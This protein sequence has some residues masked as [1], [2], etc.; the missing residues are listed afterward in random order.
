MKT[1]INVYEKLCSKI[2]AKENESLKRKSEITI[3][4][5]DLNGDH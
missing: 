5:D 4:K 3:Q 1:L 2:E